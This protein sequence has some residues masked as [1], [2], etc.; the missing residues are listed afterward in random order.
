MKLRILLLV[1]CLAIAAVP[2]AFAKSK[3]K[4]KKEAK[5]K[6]GDERGIATFTLFNG[7]SLEFSDPVAAPQLK[8]W[9]RALASSDGS[10]T[11]GQAV[12]R[13]AH[14]VQ[15]INSGAWDP[16]SYHE[17]QRMAASTGN[18]DSARLLLQ[19]GLGPSIGEALAN[20]DRWPLHA[21]AAK[22]DVE[23]LR[24]AL[25]TAHVD[26]PLPDGTTALT[27]AALSGCV[28]GISVLV[29]EGADLDLAGT[30]A[31]TPIMAAAGAGEARAVVA[32]QAAGADPNA[33]HRFAGTRALHMAVENGFEDAA[34][35]LCAGGADPDAASTST[36]G[37]ALHTAAETNASASVIRTL[38][39]PKWVPR[40]WLSAH[41]H[42]DVKSRSHSLARLLF[43]QGRGW[44]WRRR[45]SADERRH[46]GT[47]P[48]G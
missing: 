46:V 16:S 15:K 25:E 40:E 2:C 39:K 43:L 38:L 7:V 34:A 35:A 36:N 47:L 30:T 33:S 45:R 13:E 19:Y 11:H 5:A 17:Y 28:E 21:A 26:D 31:M 22:C 20:G 44:V 29:K 24:T 14:V 1:A 27:A 4:K 41:L 42:D 18:V 12:A 48:G 6:E 3:K 32:L 23:G 10:V 9:A 8:K 37:T